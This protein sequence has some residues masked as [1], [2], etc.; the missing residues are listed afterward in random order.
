MAIIGVA[1][2]LGEERRC[3][4][5]LKKLDATSIQNAIK[6]IEISGVA[7]LSLDRVE[8]ALQRLIIREKV[9]KTGDNKYYAKCKD[10]KHC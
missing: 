3:L 6:P 7:K 8:L 1:A 9:E 2:T 10:K 5:A 4:K